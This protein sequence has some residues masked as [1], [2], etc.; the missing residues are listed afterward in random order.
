MGLYR[1]GPAPEDPKKDRRI[2]HYEFIFAGRRV[3]GSTKTWRRGVAEEYEKAER[4]KLER[5]LAGLPTE[6][7]RQRIATVKQLTDAYLERAKV[8]TPKTAA[9]FTAGCLKHINEHLGSLILPDVTESVITGYM[10][11]RQKEGA[12]GRTINGELGEL[13][14]AIGHTWKVL[15]PRIP[16]LEQRHDV[17]KALTTEQERALIAAAERMAA[18]Q[19]KH[20]IK[21]RDGRVFQQR[22]GA[23]GVMMPTLIR[24]A[25]LTGMRAEELTSLRWHQID[26]EAKTITVGKAK[27]A[28]GRGR[29]IP[30]GE[31]AMMALESHLSWWA[32]RFGA[33]KPELCVFPFG[34]PQPSDPTRPIGTIAGAWESLRTE[35]KVDCR[36][37]D[38]RHTF[39]TKL[40][41]RGVSE[42]TMLALMGHMSRRMLET[43]SHIRI[44]A[45][46]EA[47]A[48][49][50]VGESAPKSS[51][52]E[53]VPTKSPT[54]SK[55]VTLQ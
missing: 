40:A 53:G 6:D 9:S 42:S 47:V 12:S 46:R 30:L 38:L 10:R 2:W 16:K 28:A 15:W 22:T 25:L 36:W 17:G 35:A 20:D 50:K 8:T 39:C 21:S 14:R 37:H 31:E 52:A 49:L 3:R 4:I 24:L 23:R 43:Y 5:A 1:R 55:R 29:V 11:K 48:G 27:T 51:A 54:K 19:D 26:M 7:N 13:A 44:A 32:K 41:E 45:K 33:A 34:S 18:G